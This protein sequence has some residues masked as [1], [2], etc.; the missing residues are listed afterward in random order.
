[1]G[2]LLLGSGYF[3]LSEEVFCRA[4][5]FG[6]LYR[7]AGIGFWPSAVLSSVPFALGH[8]YQAHDMGEVI[9]TLAITFLGALLLCWVYLAWNWNIWIPFALHAFM[10]LWWSVF[11]VG[12]GAFAG[13]LPTAMELGSAAM[14]MGLTLL[15]QRY[16][17]RGGAGPVAD[18]DANPAFSSPAQSP[19]PAS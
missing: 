8:L 13:F 6:L 11:N 12:D 3:P 19:G 14:A 4:F 5:A 7:V 10:N 18:A 9:G 1:M 16:R 2:D 15:W 17:R